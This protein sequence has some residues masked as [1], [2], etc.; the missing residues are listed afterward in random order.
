[1]ARVLVIDDDPIMLRVAS[2]SLTKAGHEVVQMSLGS[3]AVKALEKGE[4]VDLIVSDIMM[5][6]MDGF[7]VLKAVKSDK[8]TSHLPVLLCSCLSDQSSVVK[9]IKLGAAGYIAKPYQPNNLA[10]K[11]KE[12][13]GEMMAAVLIVDDEEV[14]RNLMVRILTNN[15]YRA[16]STESGEKA[17]EIIKNQSMALVITDIVMP[18]MSGIEL[19]KSIKTDK[20][21]LPVLVMT[22]HGTNNSKS[23]AISSGADGYITKPFQNTKIISEV[24]RILN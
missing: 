2:A 14:L 16:I 20:T 4:R 23:E 21:D 18:G 12:I 19:V 9:G 10:T 15:G 22:G 5:P 13:L 17:L 8:R 7:D 3:D 24:Q 11:V 6:G 1:M